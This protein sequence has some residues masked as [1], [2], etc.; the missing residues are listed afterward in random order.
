[1]TVRVVRQFVWFNPR[2]DSEEGEVEGSI[3][4]LGLADAC[5]A[6]VLRCLTEQEMCRSQRQKL[7]TDTHGK[8]LELAMAQLTE[9]VLVFVQYYGVGGRVEPV[10][11]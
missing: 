5:L 11:R 10:V 1:M 3:V 9:N 8:M 7:Y 4:W 6:T 2:A